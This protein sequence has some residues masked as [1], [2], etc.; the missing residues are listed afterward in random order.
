MSRLRSYIGKGLAVFL[1][2]FLLLTLC[3][4][5]SGFGLMLIYS[6]TRFEGNNKAVLVQLVGVLLGVAEDVTD[7]GE[8]TSVATGWLE[9]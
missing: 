2:V 1:A 3:L 7:G 5:A 4:A 6:A 9:A 8:G